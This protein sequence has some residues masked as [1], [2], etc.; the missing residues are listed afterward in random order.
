MLPGRFWGVVSRVPVLWGRFVSRYYA[1]VTK[2]CSFVTRLSGPP[3]AFASLDD[4]V[5]N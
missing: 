3:S 1:A 5:V 2:A 4:G